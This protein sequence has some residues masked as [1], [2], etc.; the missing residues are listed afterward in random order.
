MDDSVEHDVSMHSKDNVGIPS[1]VVVGTE[2]TL[3]V[4]SRDDTEIPRNTHRVFS[5]GFFF[6]WSWRGVLEECAAF[7]SLAVP[8]GVVSSSPFSGVS[9]VWWSIGVACSSTRPDNKE[10]DEK[11]DSERGG[12]GVAS[13]PSST[14]VASLCGGAA[15]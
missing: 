3:S 10:G 1:V 9:S 12:R 5:G 4:E 7:G 15:A 14:P 11:I 6:S 13:F 8:W 2:K